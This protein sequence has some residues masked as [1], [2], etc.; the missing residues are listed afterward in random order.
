MLHIVLEKESKVNIFLT[1]LM[2]KRILSEI[3]ELPEGSSLIR[4]PLDHLKEGIYGVWLC[5]LDGG[6][7][8]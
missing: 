6:G 5:R 1:E 7:E 8:V 2:G 3:R 4:L